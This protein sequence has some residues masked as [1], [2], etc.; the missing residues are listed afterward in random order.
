MKFSYILLVSALFVAC[1]LAAPKSKSGLGAPKKGCDYPGEYIEDDTIC[2]IYYECDEFLYPV[3]R[4]CAAATCF[5][6][7]TC[8][9]NRDLC[10][11][12]TKTAA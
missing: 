3:Q 8:I 10:D 7:T 2:D 1:A 6:Q 9:A 12:L 5:Y 11:C 4:F